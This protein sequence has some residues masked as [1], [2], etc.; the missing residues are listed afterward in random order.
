MCGSRKFTCGRLWTIWD[1][2]QRPCLKSCQPGRLGCVVHKAK[3]FLSQLPSKEPI[4]KEDTLA[5]SL[6]ILSRAVKMHRFIGPLASLVYFNS[7]SSGSKE[8]LILSLYFATIP[9]YDCIVL[10]TISCFENPDGLKGYFRNAP[11]QQQGY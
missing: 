8:W 4:P 11:I 2:Q 7:V 5:P 3:P 6:P 10:S 9:L 1:R